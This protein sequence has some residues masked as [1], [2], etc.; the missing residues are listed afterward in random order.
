MESLAERI[1][2]RLESLR[3]ELIE[4]RR[5]LH[6]HPELSGHEERTAGVVAERLSAMGL[7]V[8]RGVGGHG[9]VGFLRGS[10]ARPVVAYRADMDAV[11]SRAPDPV[12][13]K[14]ENPGVRHICGHDVHTTVALGIAEAL[15]SIRDE[16]PGSVQFIFQ[17]AEE[18]GEGAQ[19]MIADGALE[20]TPPD[21][22]FAV[23]CAPLPVGQ[24]ASTEGLTLACR[25]LVTITLS[26]SG[27]L[28]EA[29]RTCREIISSTAFLPEDSMGGASG[30]PIAN[31]FVT[32]QIMRSGYLTEEGDLVVVGMISP[33][34]EE[35]R[36]KARGQLDNG[37][38]ALSQQDVS[39]DVS[40]DERVISG[41]FNDSTLVRDANEAILAAVGE[42]NLVI[43][44]GAI[45]FFSEDFGFFQDSMP[46]AMYW[47]GVA[48]PEEGI[49][50][51]PHSADFAVDEEAIIVGA[52][53]FARTLLD[54][55]ET[56]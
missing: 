20:E 38:R 16:L 6:R 25:D 18:N 55:L 2:Q 19:A 54:Y 44:P 29:A 5:D 53:A 47:L 11:Q 30:L 27:D 26:G 24:I 41:V 8:R 43:M 32:A 51:M 45:P 49:S 34:S 4:I 37:L 48:N 52:K 39:Y 15:A 35:N 13:F 14:S 46:G 22:I 3:S 21:A 28:E 1:N 17:P 12:P 7:E 31:D 42:E 23:H 36:E 9:V 40:Y 50:G 33:S 10:K 56:H